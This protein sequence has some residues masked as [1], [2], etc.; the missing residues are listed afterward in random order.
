MNAPDHRDLIV[1]ESVSRKYE[2][3]SVTV[4]ALDEINLHIDEGE[5]VGDAF[6]VVRH[7]G[8]LGW[9]E[10]FD[11]VADLFDRRIRPQR[12]RGSTQGVEHEL[13]V[14]IGNEVCVAGM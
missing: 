14:A 4:T 1:L 2:L 8:Q 10:A 9:V 11:V 5:F 3:G 6:D 7:S 12:G 13:L